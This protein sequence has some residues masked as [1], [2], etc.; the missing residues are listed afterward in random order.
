L[1]SA[2]SK[3][4]FLLASAGAFAALAWSAQHGLRTL[5]P[6]PPIE[7]YAGPVSPAAAWGGVDFVMGVGLPRPGRC[8]RACL[9][10]L[11]ERM[12]K[13]LHK[14][15]RL[16][17][18]IG[19]LQAVALLHR[20]SAPLVLVTWRS[21]AG[22]C[23]STSPA[24]GTFGP[25]AD[26]AGRATGLVPGAWEA[27]RAICL[28]SLGSGYGS[29]F[30]LAGVVAAD[31][32]ALEIRVDGGR[33]TTYPLLGPV[34]APG[35]RRVFMLDLGRHDWQTLR[36]LRGGTVLDGRSRPAPKRVSGVDVP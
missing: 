16:T 34:L 12:I 29:R 22:R 21:R 32:T 13:Q 10:R 20:P 6:P 24:S 26:R 36:L 23:F 15:E 7:A 5:A 31:A 11:L 9:R 27:C 30:A 1:R 28:K 17:Q 4:L 3:T 8:D 14:R 33:N 19:A 18:P 25:C 2:T 35:A